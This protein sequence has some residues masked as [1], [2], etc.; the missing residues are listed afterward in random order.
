[1]LT[2][3]ISGLLLLQA[4]LHDMACDHKCDKLAASLHVCSLC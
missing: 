3:T 1:M 2:S 4:V